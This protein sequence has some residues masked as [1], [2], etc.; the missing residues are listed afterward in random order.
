MPKNE[1][2]V[3]LT[4]NQIK[5]DPKA[6]YRYAKRKSVIRSKIG[7]F[8][9]KGKT[10][11]SEADMCQILS[12]QYEEVCSVPRRDIKDYLF[13][14]S[15]QMRDSDENKPILDDIIVNRDNVTK[16]VAKLNNGSAMGPD[17]IPVQMY[18]YGGKYVI[19]AICDIAQSSMDTVDI[20]D[21]LKEG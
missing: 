10:I 8:N 5:S 14:E 3:Q 15:L 21:F 9:I 13:T 11:D 20:P 16:I 6:F 4:T 19:D 2:N 1:S 12:K 17:G 7:P 18:K